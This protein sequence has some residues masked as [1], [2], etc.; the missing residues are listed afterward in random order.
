MIEVID[1]GNTKAAFQRSEERHRLIARATNEVIWDS[2][3]VS[4]TQVWD[5]AVD[6]VLGY[7]DQQVTDTAW[8]EDHVHP[9]DRDRVLSKIAAVLRPGGG[10]TWSDEY[11]FL[12]A[13]GNYTI[14][15]DRAYLVREEV[16]GEPV[17]MLG[18]M[19][20]VTEKRRMEEELRERERRFRLTF[21]SANVGMAHASPDGHWLRVNGKMCEVL[22][23]GREEFMGIRFQDLTPPE[24]LETAQDRFDRLLKGRLGPYTVERRFVRKDGSRVWVSLA[25]SLVRKSSGAPDYFVCVAEDITLRKL[26]ELVPNPLTPGELEVLELVARWHKNHEIAQRLNYS[27]GMIKV[28]VRKILRKLGVKRRNE[29]ALKAVEIGLIPPPR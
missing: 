2:D 16:S 15:M 18:S 7:P 4:D 11:R 17:R 22:G 21:E 24:D 5:G 20:D 19:A 12:K 9:E 14:V 1:L 10:E 29:A 6:T 28:H 26:A 3:L 27:E 23:R 13:D 25:V 8:W